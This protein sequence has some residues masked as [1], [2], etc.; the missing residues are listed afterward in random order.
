M[1]EIQIPISDETR[2][3]LN[4]YRKKGESYDELIRRLLEIIDQVKFAEKQK[5]ILENEEHIP[6]DTI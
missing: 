2:N 4:N 1:D 3:L 6:L 5:R